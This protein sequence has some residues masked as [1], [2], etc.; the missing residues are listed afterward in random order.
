MDRGQPGK[1]MTNLQDMEGF[2]RT[3]KI[4]LENLLV[5]PVPKRPE[6]PVPKRTGHNHGSLKSCRR[7]RLASSHL[8]RGREKKAA[9]SADGTGRSHTPLIEK[10]LQIAWRP[11]FQIDEED[12]VLKKPSYVELD[13]HW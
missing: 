1:P 8:L 12:K 2:I 4:L 7:R 5:P 9:R 13:V 11:D 10:Q 3:S 6:Q